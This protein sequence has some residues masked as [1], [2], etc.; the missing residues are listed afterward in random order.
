MSSSSRV[1]FAL[2]EKLHEEMMQR[3]SDDGYSQRAKSRWICEAIEQLQETS[4]LEDLVNYADEM[5]EMQKKE[6]ISMPSSLKQKLGK[7]TI[8]VRKK[9]IEME[10]VQSRIIRASIMQRLLRG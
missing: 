3:I 10:G 2:P 8:K 4:N 1:S 6:I 7:L 9:Y 5:S